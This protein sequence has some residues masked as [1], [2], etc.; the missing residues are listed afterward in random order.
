MLREADI[1]K[2]NADGEECGEDSGG[3]K[4]FDVEPGGFLRTAVFWGGSL[5]FRN[6]S[7]G[8]FFASSFDSRY[9]P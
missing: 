3:E 2:I 9:T 5:H 4:L 8:S 7:C 6:S 1:E